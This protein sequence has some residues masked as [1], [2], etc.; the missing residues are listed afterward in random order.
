MCLF[1]FSHDIFFWQASVLIASRLVVIEMFR[2]PSAAAAK[3][4]TG[5][6]IYVL[7]YTHIHEHTYTHTDT[8]RIHTCTLT[9]IHAYTYSNTHT[10]IHALIEGMATPEVS[11]TCTVVIPAQACILLF[12]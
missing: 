1:D 4:L 5:T 9:H 12:M 8:D 6:H 3:A 10:R 2:D 7:I 11:I